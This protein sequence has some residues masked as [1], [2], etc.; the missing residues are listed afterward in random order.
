[1][2]S[3]EVKAELRRIVKNAKGDNLERAETAFRKCSE[4]E[5]DRKYGQCRQTPRQILEEY[6]QGRRLWEEVWAWV[7]T[8]T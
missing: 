7:S 6:R 3:D 1:M 8:L 4:A 2:V 5:L